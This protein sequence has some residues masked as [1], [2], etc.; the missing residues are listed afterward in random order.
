[1]RLTEVQDTSPEP[2]ASSIPDRAVRQIQ[3][4]GEDISTI[5][6]S[7]RFVPLPTVISLPQACAG[8]K[9]PRVRHL[10]AHSHRVGNGDD[11]NK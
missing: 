5:L 9:D 6:R 7:S 10:L 8:R 11:Q 3:H 2:D 1:M 4:D